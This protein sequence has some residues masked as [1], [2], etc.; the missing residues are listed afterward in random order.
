MQEGHIGRPAGSLNDREQVGSGDRH[1]VILCLLSP[2]H[3]LWLSWLVFISPCSPKRG[4]Q[5]FLELDPVA[6]IEQVWTLP[7]VG[8]GVQ[9]ALWT[10]S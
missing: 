8:C 3:L 4:H 6:I 1:I 2:C 10:L 9:K 7:A 5:L